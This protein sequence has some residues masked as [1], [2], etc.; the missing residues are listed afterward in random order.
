MEMAPFLSK[1]DVEQRGL[2]GAVLREVTMASTVG[3]LLVELRASAIAAIVLDV[4]R[5][6]DSRLA[7]KVQDAL[8]DFS[9]V[10]AGE[11]RPPCAGPVLTTTY[12][13]SW[14]HLLSKKLVRAACG[15][16]FSS[17]SISAMDL[18]AL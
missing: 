1:C 6:A 15:P 2:I 8:C 16:T 3:E 7:T 17:K 12:H 18:V 13:S 10:G 11:C 5:R 14:Q 9:G 4:E